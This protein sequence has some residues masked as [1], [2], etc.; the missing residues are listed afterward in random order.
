MS[1]DP[2]D[3]KQTIELLKLEGKIRGD[4]RI[5]RLSAIDK[6][7]PRKLKGKIRQSKLEVEFIGDIAW[8]E[9]GSEELLHKTYCRFYRLGEDIRLIRIAKSRMF[10]GQSIEEIAKV[11]KLSTSRVFQLITEIKQRLE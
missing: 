9:V 4:P 10:L 7:D 3:I 6:L 1:L 5:A 8:A 2:E 11:E